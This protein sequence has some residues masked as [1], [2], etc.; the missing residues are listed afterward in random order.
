[1]VPS[2]NYFQ[3]LIQL[4]THFLLNSPQMSVISPYFSVLLSSFK[5]HLP[6]FAAVG[7]LKKKNYSQITL[8]NAKI[9][10]KY[11][12]NFTENVGLSSYVL[13]WHEQKNEGARSEIFPRRLECD[14]S[15]LV[16]RCVTQREIFYSTCRPVRRIEYTKISYV[17]LCSDV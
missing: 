7:F 3:Q 8:W 15:L 17:I 16:T 10:L 13:G 1:M 14:S 11:L 6:L 2:L 12:Y 5:G 4:A 9:H